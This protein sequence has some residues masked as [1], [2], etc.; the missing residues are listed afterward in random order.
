MR[1]SEKGL[2]L[3]KS[4][5]SLVLHPYLDDAGVPT[6]GYGTTIYP[7]GKHVTLKDDPISPGMADG[8]LFYDV[9]H[10]SDAVNVMLQGAAIPLNQNQFD[11]LVDFAYNEGTGALHGST[12]LRLVKAN[13]SDFAIEHAFHLWNKLHK[14]GVLVY[15]SDLDARRGKEFELYKTPIQ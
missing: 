3:I 10:V 11:S 5:E 1:P 2:A 14:D 4:N 7:S 15:S 12:L 13:P 6:I 8:F 9:D